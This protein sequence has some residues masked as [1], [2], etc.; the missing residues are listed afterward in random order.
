MSATVLLGAVL[1]PTLIV[2]ALLAAMMM[3]R[4]GD[5]E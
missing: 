5:S 2:A 3:G 1:C 4:R